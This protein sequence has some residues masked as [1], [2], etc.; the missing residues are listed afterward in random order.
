MRNDK[1]IIKYLSGLMNK[2]EE[3]SFILE[4]NNSEIL[5]EKLNEVK[6]TLN[7]LKEIKTP[8][9][10]EKYF[11]NLRVRINERKNMKKKFFPGFAAAAALV[12][13][14]ILMISKLLIFSDENVIE[15][16]QISWDEYFSSLNDNE[17]LFFDVNINEDIREYTIEEKLNYVGKINSLQNNDIIISLPELDAKTISELESKKI[18]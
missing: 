11:V 15:P 13:I 14:I 9:I 8:E 16:E 17:I 7:S 1:Q 12:T 2:S 6:N 3:D 4:L 10:D 18:L 5:R